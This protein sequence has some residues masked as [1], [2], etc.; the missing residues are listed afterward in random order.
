MYVDSFDDFWV[1]NRNDVPTR[2]MLPD[3]SSLKKPF[4]LIYSRQ[5]NLSSIQQD[6][7]M[8][9]GNLSNMKCPLHNKHVI[10]A[11]YLCGKQCSFKVSLSKRFRCVA[12]Y[13]CPFKDFFFALCKKHQQIETPN[14]DMFLLDLNYETPYS[15]LA[16]SNA[17]DV[18]EYDEKELSQN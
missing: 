14:N 7:L 6:Y 5:P 3:A 18:T 1:M 16:Q 10:S 2:Q 17:V 9:M 15:L 12:S 4:L 8:G 13:Q 11:P